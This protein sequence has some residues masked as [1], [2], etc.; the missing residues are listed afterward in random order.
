MSADAL[1]SPSEASFLIPN[2]P[3]SPR[4]GP[5]RAGALGA[6]AVAALLLAACSVPSN[7][8]ESYGEAVQANFVAGCTGQIQES[9]GTT[10]TLASS[11]YCRC[12]YEVFEASVPF[13]DDA[14]DDSRYQGYPADAPTFT[15]L[16]SDF[17][18]QDDPDRVFD[19]LPSSVREGLERCQGGG[20]PVAPTTTAPA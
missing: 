20:G 12:A 4:W 17:S 15:S 10:T 13:N 9:G 14:R 6:L 2:A 8:P 3:R 1:P 7:A 5:R 16:N 19:D 11:D 18:S